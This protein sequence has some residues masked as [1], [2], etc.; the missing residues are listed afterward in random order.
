MTTYEQEQP[1]NIDAQDQPPRIFIMKHLGFFLHLF[2]FIAIISCNFGTNP[3]I[4]AFHFFRIVRCYVTIMNQLSNNMLN[5]HC[6]AW[7]EDLGT[8]D[9]LVNTNF[10]WTFMTEILHTVHYDCDAQWRK[11]T[12]ILIHF[13]TLKCSLTMSV[14]GDIAYG[15]QWMMAFTCTTFPKRNLRSCFRGLDGRTKHIMLYK[16]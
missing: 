4:H 1:T 12:S 7:L 8:H 16:S 13:G 14:G 15:K 2:L 5:L 6:K 9:L 3:S 10:S 11:G